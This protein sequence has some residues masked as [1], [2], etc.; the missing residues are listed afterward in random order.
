MS[1][2]L[3]TF[4]ALQTLL[5]QSLVPVE[6]CKSIRDVLN[7]SR[8]GQMGGSARPGL[9]PVKPGLLGTVR[10]WAG[11]SKHAGSIS[12]PSSARIGS[13]RAGPVRLARKKQTE[14]R[15]MRAGK[16]VLV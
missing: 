7:C 9:G 12:Y 10:K 13:K 6:D 14:K 11:P 8:D 15:A 3:L 2:Y 5:S 1:I 4:E 16:H